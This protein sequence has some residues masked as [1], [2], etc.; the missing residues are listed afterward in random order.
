VAGSNQWYNYRHQSDVC[1][2]YHI[3]LGNG[4]PKANIITLAFDDIANAPQNPFPGTM[5]NT[6]TGADPGVNVY[7]GCEIDYKG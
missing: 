5:Y 3:L 4:I 7:A 1:H 2:A 6:P